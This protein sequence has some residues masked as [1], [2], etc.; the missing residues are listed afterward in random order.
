MS[1]SHSVPTLFANRRDIE[2]ELARLEGERLTLLSR[3]NWISNQREYLLE[4][5]K[6]MYQE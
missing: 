5:L 3:L 4:H 1:F 2:K 6:Q